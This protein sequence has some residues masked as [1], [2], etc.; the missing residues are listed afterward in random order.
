[1][2]EDYISRLNLTAPKISESDPHQ[3]CFQNDENK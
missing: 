3:I 1:M 2:F